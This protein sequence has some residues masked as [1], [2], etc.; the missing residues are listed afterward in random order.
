MIFSGGMAVS[1]EM[2]N[3]GDSKLQRDVVA[4]IDH[5][6]SDRPGRRCPFSSVGLG[7]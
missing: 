2:H 3:T 7:L 4:I 6:L 1:V 5:V